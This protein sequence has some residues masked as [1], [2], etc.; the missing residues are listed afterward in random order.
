MQPAAWV[1]DTL[2]G[3][4]PALTAGAFL[5]AMSII[6]LPHAAQ[7]GPGHVVAAL[8]LNAVGSSLVS[9]MPLGLITD[10]VRPEDRA[11]ANALLRTATDL[12][13]LVGAVS[14]GALA[15]A[16]AMQS[17]FELSGS[18]MLLSS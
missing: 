15:D 8:A 14:I 18:C 11:V 1:C 10:A 16:T 3:K 5:V 9:P 13:M 12:G 4:G 17:C 7:L 6:A 2:L